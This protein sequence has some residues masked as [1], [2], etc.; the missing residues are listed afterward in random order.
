MLIDFLLYRKYRKLKKKIEREVLTDM[1]KS[2]MRIIET[3]ELV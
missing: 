2:D 1:G 3:I